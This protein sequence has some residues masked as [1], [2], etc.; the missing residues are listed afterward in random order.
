MFE[1]PKL[2]YGFDALEPYL[3]A[4]T[5]ELHHGKHHATY[6]AKLNEA[7][8]QSPEW[9][10]KSLEDIVKGYAEAPEA[11]RGALHNHGGGHLNH[12]LFWKCLCPP[13][14]GGGEPE[15]KAGEALGSAFG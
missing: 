2:P 7:L 11:I 5:M 12:S 4:K 1:L 15:G 9:E 6:V 14:G 10:A 13:V 8:Q 3:D